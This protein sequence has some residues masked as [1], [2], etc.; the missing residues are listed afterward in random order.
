MLVL[1]FTW[2]S[3]V[4]ETNL[5]ICAV[6]AVD[7]LRLKKLLSDFCA[8]SCAQ[9]LFLRFVVSS[10]RMSLQKQLST[11]VDFR[12]LFSLDLLLVEQASTC[13]TDAVCILSVF[14]TK[15]NMYTKIFLGHASGMQLNCAVMIFLIF[16]GISP[17]FKVLTNA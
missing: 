10:C 9:G 13:R 11:L 8:F 15:G 7:S 6:F 4:N 16:M 12:L 5:P 1:L 17:G 3:I 2:D 14:L